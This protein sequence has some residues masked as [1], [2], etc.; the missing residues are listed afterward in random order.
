MSDDASRRDF[1][2]IEKS[3]A[4]DTDRIGAE[5][6]TELEATTPK[7]ILRAF[8]LLELPRLR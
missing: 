6:F 5:G 7:D 4:F 1:L 3:C 8:P 2:Q